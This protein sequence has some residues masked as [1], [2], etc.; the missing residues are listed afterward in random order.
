MGAEGD[1]YNDDVVRRLAIDGTASEIFPSEHLR[2]NIPDSTKRRVDLT[3]AYAALN[4]EDSPLHKNANPQEKKNLHEAGKFAIASATFLESGGSFD[5]QALDKFLSEQLGG[6]EL[7]TKPGDGP[8][9]ERLAKLG[10]VTK[11]IIDGEVEIKDALEF[12]LVP[13]DQA[14]K[15]E[16][17]VK[18]VE[19]GKIG[20]DVSKVNNAT[21]D[22]EIRKSIAT[23]KTVGSP[24]TTAAKNIVKAK[25]S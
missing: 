17:S 22:T 7:K 24:S 8:R 25:R 11:A 6:S 19:H 13:E 5:D 3:Y 21:S 16:A 12:G 4:S 2:D 23:S 14:K 18:T 9:G 15:F 1:R 10:E 20:A